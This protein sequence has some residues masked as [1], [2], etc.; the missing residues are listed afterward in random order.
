MGYGDVVPYSHSLE[1]YMES[2]YVFNGG[3]FGVLI[4]QSSGYNKYNVYGMD[5]ASGPSFAFI[6]GFHVSDSP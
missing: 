4:T 6:T 1:C 2:L 5:L 3:M